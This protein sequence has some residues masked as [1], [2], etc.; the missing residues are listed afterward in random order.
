MTPLRDFLEAPAKEVVG[1]LP[2]DH[3]SA[4]S[5]NMFRRCKEQYRHRYVLGEKERPSGALITGTAFH[6]AQQ[7]SF[8]EMIG[9][10]DPAPV[11]EVVEKF[12]T[13]FSEGI[14]SVG[15]AKEIYWD[16]RP[17]TERSGGAGATKLYR[18]V[19]AP[20]VEPVYVEHE[21]ELTVDDVALPIQG[22][23]DVVQEP[24]VID[25]KTAKRAETKI[26]SE[27]RIQGEIYQLALTKPVE[28]HVATKNATPKTV[29]PLEAEGL[30]QDINLEQ[31]A[32]TAKMIARFEKEVAWCM[33]TF[34]PDELWPDARSHP[35]A[36]GFC[37]WGPNAAGTCG[38]WA[39]GSRPA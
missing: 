1:L 39:F 9:K 11:A 19:V 20:H 4:S 14:E 7:Y 34:G 18:E 12:H 32:I 37:G 27:W 17:E 35:F 13:T 16:T 6:E 36:C 31:L 23:I 28:W 24:S 33:A 26:K 3:H 2:T 8:E 15:G 21:F 5:I 38:H 22:R 29:T 30:Y 10:G 25:M